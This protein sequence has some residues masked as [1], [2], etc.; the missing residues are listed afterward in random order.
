MLTPS[1]LLTS[2]LF[3]CSVLAAHGT[4]THTHAHAHNHTHAHTSMAPLEGHTTG[5]LSQL[6]QSQGVEGD[7]L[8]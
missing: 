4:V 3:L 1:N 5:G 8:S 2:S 6:A 7:I